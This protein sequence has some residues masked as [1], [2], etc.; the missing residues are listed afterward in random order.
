MKRLIIFA[1]FLLAAACVFGQNFEAVIRDITGTV[2]LKTGGSA[3]WIPANDGDRIQKATLI[4]TGFKSMAL[5][6]IGDSAILVLPLT[7]LSL[8]ELLMQDNTETINVGLQSGRARLD[9]NPPAGAKTN[10]SVQSPMATASVRGTS[11]EMDTVKINVFEG[12]VK[13][14]SA[15]GQPVLVY[16]GQSSL[17][18]METGRVLNPFNLAATERR[19][20]D[21]PG[22]TS[23]RVSSDQ[24]AVKIIG[25]F[26]ANLTL[27]PLQ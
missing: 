9:V 2:E 8:E 15:A 21:L 19:L 20:P 14:E 12:M 4:S 1:F 26:K 24:N 18:D 23:G 25:Y 22:Q 17:V 11:F 3:E 5:L 10:L 6:E 7:R 13:F 27:E 16:A